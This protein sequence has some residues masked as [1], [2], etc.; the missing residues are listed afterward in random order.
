MAESGLTHVPEQENSIRAAPPGCEVSGSCIGARVSPVAW[1]R[2]RLAR[3]LRPGE[4]PGEHSE[5]GFTMAETLVTVLLFGIVTTPLAGVF[6]SGF[7]AAAGAAQRTDAVG[8]ATSGISLVESLPYSKAGFYA[9]QPGYQASYDGAPTVTIASS[10]PAGYTPPI[11]PVRSETVGPI[12]YTVTTAIVWAGAS[13]ATSDTSV[14]YADAYKE[15]F[16][17]ASWTESGSTQSVTEKTLV[18]S[19]AL[20]PYSGPEGG[21][22]STT[23]TSGT[24]GSPELAAASVP[25]APAGESEVYLSWSMPPG[26]AAGYFVVEWST[27]AAMASGSLQASPHEASSVT[28]YDVAGLSAGTTYFFEVV[29]YQ[30]GTGQSLASNQVNAT[31]DSSSS[32]TCTLGAF[33]VMGQTSGNTGK[34]YLNSD[35]T[36]SENLS[37]VLDTS[38]SCSGPFSV[39]ASPQGST[40]PDPGSPYALPIANSGQWSGAVDSAGQAGWALGEHSFTVDLSG[41]PVSPPVAQTFLV[42]SYLPASERSSSQNQC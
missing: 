16:V 27:N 10:T 38:G 23:G 32:S 9:D 3:V 8:I 15:A 7:Q 11:V 39:A 41:L 25:A 22:G 4:R 42:C 34:T 30:G 13:S 1:L 24:L 18:Y 17:T 14:P 12:T 20:G 28:S 31:T 26:T 33:T 29:A 6:T 5:G 35:G 21:S 36:M 19:G 2:G 37:L 40:T